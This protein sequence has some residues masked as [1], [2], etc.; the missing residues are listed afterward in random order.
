VQD[1]IWQDALKVGNRV[2]HASCYAE[3][4]KEAPAAAA[5]RTGTPQGRTGT[6]D[7]V[8]GK[9]KAEVSSFF[10]FQYENANGLLG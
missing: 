9:R 3:V 7:S 4:T 10:N 1:W 6:P 2:Y 5:G 8:L